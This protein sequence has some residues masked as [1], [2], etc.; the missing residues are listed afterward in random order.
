M[1][2][3]NR[4]MGD[5]A[6]GGYGY[7]QGDPGLFSFLAKAVPAVIKFFKKPAI[8]TIASAA[9]GAGLVEAGGAVCRPASRPVARPAGA[10]GLCRFSRR[11]VARNSKTAGP[12]GAGSRWPLPSRVPPEK[13]QAPAVQVCKKS[14]Y[15][16][17]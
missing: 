8:R 13:R 10:P 1:S 16:Y 17:R 12:A 14:P 11:R 7:P 9:A 3:Y 6:T 2:Y 15:E 5:Y 4:P